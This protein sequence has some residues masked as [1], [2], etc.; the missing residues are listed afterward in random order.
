MTYCLTKLIPV[1]IAPIRRLSVNDKLYPNPLNTIRL[2][3]NRTNPLPSGAEFVSGS[4]FIIVKALE[5]ASASEVIA[6]RVR[7]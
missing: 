5:T 1:N 7:T 6:V 4:A 2:A 3:M